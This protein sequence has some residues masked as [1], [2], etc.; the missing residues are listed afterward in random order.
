MIL[1]LLIHY[2][3]A[4]QDDWDM[5]VGAAVLGYNIQVH[6]S[7]GMTPFELAITRAASVPIVESS[8]SEEP[9]GQNQAQFR[10]SFLKQ[11]KATS[12]T[13]KETLE[14]AQM[15]Y[16]KVYVVRPRQSPKW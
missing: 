15:R 8:V 5:N 9:S 10:V 11:L 7:T 13:T 16:R 4:E 14:K 3:A 2:V 1:E 6:V 12:R